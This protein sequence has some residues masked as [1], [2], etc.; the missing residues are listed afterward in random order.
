M[1]AMR[2]ILPSLVG[3]V[4]WLVAVT[5]AMAAATTQLVLSPD[6]PT[7]A[8]IAEDP[9]LADRTTFDLRLTTTADWTNSSLRFVLG[10]GSFYNAA[11][12]GDIPTTPGQWNT[13]GLQHLRQD[14]FVAAPPDF[15]AWPMIVGRHMDDGAGPAIFSAAAVSVIWAD[16]SASY[17]PGTYTLARLTVSNDAVGSYYGSSFDSALPGTPQPFNGAINKQLRWD[18]DPLTSGAQGG[19]GTWNTAGNGFWNGAANVAWDNA[20]NDVAIFGASAA[21]VTVDAVTASALRFET[22]GYTLAGGAIALTGSARIT[23]DQNASITSAIVSTGG[24]TKTGPAT[25]AI[26]GPSTYTGLTRIEDGTLKVEAMFALGGTSAVQVL[27]DAQLD[28]AASGSLSAPVSLLGTA[29]AIV[30]A[31]RTV[32]AAGLSAGGLNTLDVDGTLACDGPLAIAAG[33]RLTKTGDGEV[34]FDG[35]QTHG[36]GALLEIIGGTV[37]LGTDAGSDA[38]HDLSID[39]SNATLNFDA[40]QHLDTLIIGS[41]GSVVLRHAGIVLVN[42]LQV[43]GLDLGPMTLTPEPATLA[44]LA[45]GAAAAAAA[46]RRRK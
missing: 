32:S 12:G 21:T 42:D 20:R 22:A 19:A 24:L 7:A 43:G 14:T 10:E 11:D 29:K 13:P 23:A 38:A 1:S 5:T 25:L 3:C 27:N 46:R 9:A 40:N 34:T 28:V 41:G 15:T 8:A 18:T 30:E 35:P 17:G 44:L 31:G 37:N 45:L 39:V 2:R 36:A 26:S 6:Q 4:A 16:A 33:C